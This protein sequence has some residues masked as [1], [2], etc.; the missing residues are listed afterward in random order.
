MGIFRNV[1]II[2]GS[3]G[4]GGSG[5]GGGNGTT[6][7]ETTIDAGNRVNLHSGDDTTI[8]GAQVSGNSVVA[9]IGG[10]P[11]ISNLQDSD[12]YDSKQNSI[13][14][15][16]SFTF[17]SMTGS[18]CISFS[19]GKMHSD[20]NSVMEQSGIFAGDGGFDIT[21]GSLAPKGSAQALF[22]RLK[23]FILQLEL[24]WIYS[25][26][27][28]LMKIICFKNSVYTGFEIY[29]NAEGFLIMSQI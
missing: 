3:G 27:R 20:Y 29:L 1:C 14:G 28:L 19:K 25:G 21:V 11:T 18:G 17:G 22:K 9:D 8:A 23:P 10:D 2:S 24:F 5:G 16:A 26:V 15:G 4:S 13:S 12:R 6:H 7:N